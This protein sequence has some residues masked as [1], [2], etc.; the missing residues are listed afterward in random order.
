M[1]LAR[2][3]TGRSMAARIE[4][5]ATT[6]S[7]STSVNAIFCRRPEEQG[8]YLMAL[9]HLFYTLFRQQK[10][11]RTLVR[12]KVRGVDAVRCRESDRILARPV[13]GQGVELEALLLGFQADL[14]LDRLGQDP[15]VPHRAR[16]RGQQHDR[17]LAQG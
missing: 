12:R 1:F 17:G 10:P 7:S 8:A 14:A 16:E 9:L 2:E 15:V 3:S 13:A 5:M 11:V 4:M 6:T